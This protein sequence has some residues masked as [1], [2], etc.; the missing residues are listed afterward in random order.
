M[1]EV[2]Y[3]V[4]YEAIAFVSLVLSGKE[5]SDAFLS[6]LHESF[7]AAVLRKETDM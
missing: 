2:C 3:N 4:Q 6:M 7:S 5:N 1:L